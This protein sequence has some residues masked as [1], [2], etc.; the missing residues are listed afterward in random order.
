VFVLPR[1]AIFKRYNKQKRF[2]NW[3]KLKSN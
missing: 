2:N 1:I 3:L